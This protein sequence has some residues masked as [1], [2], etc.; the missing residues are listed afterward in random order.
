MRNGLQESLEEYAARHGVRP[1]VA[2]PF[3]RRDGL[4]ILGGLD[5]KSGLPWDFGGGWF[6]ASTFAGVCRCG[7]GVVVPTAKVV[8]E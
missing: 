7:V 8:W 2:R 6:D 4:G 1:A 3:W 5:D